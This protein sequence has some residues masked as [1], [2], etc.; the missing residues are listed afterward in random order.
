MVA[1]W[2]I[3][4]ISRKQL[5]LLRIIEELKKNSVQFFSFNENID[6]DSPFS[7]AMLQILGSFA[8][9]ERNQ[10]I[11]NVKMAM[12]ERAEQGKC[13]GGSV[14][15]YRSENKELIVV[16]EEAKLVQHIFNLYI[17][18][19]GYKLIA[20]QLNKE[21]FKTKKNGAFA[22]ATIRTI[23]MNPLYAGFIRFNQVE[24]WEEKRRRGATHN[25]ILSQG[26]HE[27]II[28]LNT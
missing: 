16:E 7:I 19:K 5:D 15:G 8:E 3:N 9:L 21:G 14:L 10:T 2:R 4:R 28:D 6:A 1:V 18:R 22:I 24:Q 13:D 20:N 11:E 27:A 23:V 12:N 17:N 25:C 26:E